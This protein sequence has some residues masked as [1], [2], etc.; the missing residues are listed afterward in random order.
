MHV[1]LI[2]LVVCFDAC[3]AL[4]VPP[5]LNRVPAL[6]ICMKRAYAESDGWASVEHDMQLFRDT[7]PDGVPV[8]T[9]LSCNA[10]CCVYEMSM[11]G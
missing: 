9:I 11:G 1:L 5:Q 2:A 3:G 7:S 8:K 4:G 6:P 10:L